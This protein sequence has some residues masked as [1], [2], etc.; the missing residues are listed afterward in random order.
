MGSGRDGEEAGA[1]EP[2]LVQSTWPCPLLD[3]G[4]W[5][6]K[7]DPSLTQRGTFH[8]DGQF[9]VPVD[10]MQA[11]MY[12]LRWTLLEQPSIQ[13]TLDCPGWA[14]VL[15]AGQGV[16]GCGAGTGLG[17]C[18][19]TFLVVM[20]LGRV[21][22]KGFTLP[23]PRGTEAP[24]SFI[25]QNRIGH[26]LFAATVLGLGHSV[27]HKGSPDPCSQVGRHKYTSTQTPTG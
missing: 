27:G 4:F 11:R 5:K 23:A 24:G 22:M 13:V 17:R 8:L 25:Q 1:I 3:A 6:N 2:A 19:L 26:L 9:T 7:F 12:P 15:G 14:W 18:A 16:A 21:A 20:S 10:M